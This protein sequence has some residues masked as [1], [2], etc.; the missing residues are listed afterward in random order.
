M[1]VPAVTCPTCSS[2]DLDALGKDAA[3]DLRLRCESCGAEWTRTPNRPC[4]KCSSIDV[5]HTDA[6][7]YLCRSCGHGWRD[8]P[9]ARAPE[10][11]AKRPTARARTARAPVRA[12]PRGGAA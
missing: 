9:V 11:V 1:P 5:S 4:P 2:D 10:P 3:G 8:V 12:A 6:T 7:G